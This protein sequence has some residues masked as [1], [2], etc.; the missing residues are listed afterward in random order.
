MRWKNKLLAAEAFVQH[1]SF[2]SIYNEHALGGCL[3]FEHAL[4]GGIDR[5]SIVITIAIHIGVVL[6]SIYGCLF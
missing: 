6:S 2:S 5:L 1:V 4:N 3:Q